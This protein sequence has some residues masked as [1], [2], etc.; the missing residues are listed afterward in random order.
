MAAALIV[1]CQPKWLV[2][3]PG[4]CLCTAHWS[5]MLLQWEL[6]NDT[7]AVVPCLWCCRLHTLTAEMVMATGV[8]GFRP[9]ESVANVLAALHSTTHNG[10][11]IAIAPEGE[12]GRIPQR[13]GQGSHS[14]LVSL[15]QMGA[16][17][18]RHTPDPAAPLGSP[19]PL[20]AASLHECPESVGS[21]EP[22]I[23]GQAGSVMTC[24][25]GRLE[26]IILRSQLLVLLQRRHFCDQH[27]R[28]VGR[29]YCEKAEIELEVSL[30]VGRTAGIQAWFTAT[31]L[32]VTT[33][34]VKP[35]RMPL[36]QL[37]AVGYAFLRMSL[38]CQRAS[39]R[40]LHCASCKAVPQLVVH[41][42]MSC[43]LL[44][45]CRLRCAHFSGGTSHI[46][47]M[48]LQQPPLWRL[49]SCMLRAASTCA[50]CTLTCGLI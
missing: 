19:T 48:S 31:W 27:G 22:S 14:S 33:S 7:S 34:C 42:A 15:A 9:V 38:A 40:G 5:A 39:I 1:G 4:W 36:M 23:E 12:Q 35:G 50:A 11:P 47:A 43:C 3:L 13:G 24:E 30:G 45:C 18:G 26:G 6:A 29:E 8:V 2:M 41:V 32:T 37:F 44:C 20:A 21:P 25:G 10:F 17:S 49:C 28:P 46:T 16:A